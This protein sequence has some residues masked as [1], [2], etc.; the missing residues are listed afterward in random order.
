MSTYKKTPRIKMTRNKFITLKI[1]GQNDETNSYK[2]WKL[3]HI[4]FK[5]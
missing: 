4:N 1:R 5:L 3:Q 2:K